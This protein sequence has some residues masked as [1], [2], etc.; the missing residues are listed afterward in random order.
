MSLRSSEDPVA[1]AWETNYRFVV[2]RCISN[3]GTERSFCHGI[4][5]DLL[6][7]IAYLEGV[8]HESLSCPL[9]LHIGTDGGLARRDGL[10]SINQSDAGG[11]H[12]TYHLLRCAGVRLSLI[13]V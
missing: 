9:V 5:C 11:A 3:A 4:S 13:V 10:R 12:G 7:R 8:V 2:C 1:G 6:A